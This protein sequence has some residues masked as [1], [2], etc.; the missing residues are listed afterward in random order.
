LGYSPRRENS[1]SY[2]PYLGEIDFKEPK[3]G[4]WIKK[5]P[6][7]SYDWI[8][9]NIR[10]KKW[11]PDRKIHQYYILV[12]CFDG[13]KEIKVIIKFDHFPKSPVFVKHPHVLNPKD[14]DFL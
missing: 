5:H 11:I 8:D 7:A 9:W 6:F 14:Y 10:W 13:T 2:R 12:D 3:I 4:N 1:L